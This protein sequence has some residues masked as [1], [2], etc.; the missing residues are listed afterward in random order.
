MPV[1]RQ[2]VS[3]NRRPGIPAGALTPEAEPGRPSP[4]RPSPRPLPLYREL[5][6][7]G[8]LVRKSSSGNPHRGADA[9][10]EPPRPS[11]ANRPPRPLPP[12]KMAGEATRSPS[13]RRDGRFPGAAFPPVRRAASG[14]SGGTSG[15]DARSERPHSGGRTGSRSAPVRRTVGA[16]CRRGGRSVGA[17]GSSAGGPGPPRRGAA[18][19]TAAR[20][21][22]RSAAPAPGSSGR[23]V[24]P[25]SSA[26]FGPPVGSHRFV[27]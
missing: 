23:F 4:A 14:V 26:R 2:S 20:R 21:V 16:R 7:G 8:V 15:R 12:A 24:G 9:E 25:I 6:V 3:G 22:G 1:V 17:A 5:V 10:A 18:E 13:V 19:R 27:S 11:P